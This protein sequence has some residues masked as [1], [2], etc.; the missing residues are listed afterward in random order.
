MLNL[1][2][3]TEMK[4]TF[5]YVLVLENW[6]W[7]KKCFLGYLDTA[8]LFLFFF[9][10]FPCNRVVPF[11]YH[12]VDFAV[13]RVWYCIMLFGIFNGK[14]SFCCEDMEKN[15]VRFKKIIL[16]VVLY[17]NYFLQE[18]SLGDCKWV[19]M[20]WL[21][22]WGAIDFKSAVHVVSPQSSAVIMK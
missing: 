1:S 17:T 4:K 10:F 11:L 2:Q 15:M 21:I 19:Y 8:A 5:Q 18:A 22:K 13:K 6:C 7:W 14:C 12:C 20:S 3:N 9:F 16:Y